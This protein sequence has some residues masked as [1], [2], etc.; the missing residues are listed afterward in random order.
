MKLLKKI[1][2]FYSLLLN[3]SIVCS[4]KK[5]T[6][7][8]PTFSTL[9][10]KTLDMTMITINYKNLSLLN[11]E[12]CVLFNKHHSLL[13]MT[14]NY[15]CKSKV[16]NLS[17][18][19]DYL[20]LLSGIIPDNVFVSGNKAVIFGPVSSAGSIVLEDVNS[21]INFQQVEKNEKLENLD[22]DL[23]GNGGLFLL[24]IIFVC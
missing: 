2:M 13:K 7:I 14:G 21:K 6:Q 4:T 12:N 18:E 15:L 19:E 23:V 11:L 17:N 10:N 9:K 20:M 24:T 1:V 8:K 16:I 22:V 5:N 3:F